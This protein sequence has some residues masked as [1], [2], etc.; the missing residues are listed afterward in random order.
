M[1]L[2]HKELSTGEKSRDTIDCQLY[3]ENPR[4]ITT[5][6][7]SQRADL[8]SLLSSRIRTP[9]PDNLRVRVKGDVSTCVIS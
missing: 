2:L 6:H 4:P 3:V 5:M 7:S 9:Q 1:Y 8:P